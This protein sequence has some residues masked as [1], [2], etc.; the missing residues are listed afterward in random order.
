VKSKTLRL[1]VVATLITVAVVIGHLL[2]GLD[3]TEIDREIRNSLH[4]IG[5]AFIAAVIFEAL[6]L[7]TAR[8]ALTTLSIVAVL[9]ALA[10][11]VQSLD[12]K[13]FDL[14]DLYRDIAGAVLYIVARVL[15]NWTKVEGR[16]SLI[17][18]SART[19]SMALGILLFVPLSYWS[20]AKAGIAA[21]FP[22]IIDFDGRWDSYTYKPVNSEVTLVTGGS[23]AEKNTGA[24]A[25]IV[26]L[27]RGWSGLS[28]K[29]VVSDWSSFQFLTMRAAVIGV[30]ESTI[31]VD[32]SDVEH[33]GYRI[34]HHVG[35][36]SAG[37]EP[38]VIR[39]PLHAVSEIPGRPELD[40]SNVTAVY[41]IAKTGRKGKNNS[42]EIRMILD[43]IRL[44]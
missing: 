10:E 4:V 35:A 18:F 30:Q 21:K 7:S 8:A 11:F 12:G 43:D 3:A 34:Q 2:P 26:L 23:S 39:F 27:H 6:P 25:E 41:I 22:T 38:T 20:Y 36:S 14:G 29:P 33:P 1:I 37:P 17:R 15:W 24:F 16:S 28:I 44:E 5:F 32:I 13:G 19:V 9:G 40:L 31:T 42:G